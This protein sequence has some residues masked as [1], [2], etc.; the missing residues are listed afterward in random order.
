MSDRSDQSDT[1]TKPHHQSGWPRLIWPG[2]LKVAGITGIPAVPEVIPGDLPAAPVRP[3]RGRNDACWCGSGK[4]YK[5]CHLPED[6]NNQ[7]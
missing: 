6:L 2:P 5:L 1:Q 7:R 4:K 3:K